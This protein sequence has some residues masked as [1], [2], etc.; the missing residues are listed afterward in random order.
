MLLALNCD[1]IGLG[2]NREVTME[3]D[4]FPSEHKRIRSE[5]TRK[6]YRGFLAHFG[7]FLSD[8][9]L[10]IDAVHPADI[11]RFAAWV[12]GSFNPRTGT[13]GLSDAAVQSHLVAVSSYYKWRRCRNKILPHPVLNPHSPSVAFQPRIMSRDGRG[14]SYCGDPLAR[15]NNS[16]YRRL[17]CV[18]TDS[19]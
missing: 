10:T 2:F 17:S 5:C 6:S 14:V 19:I 11:R 8:N 3:I 13:A 1:L 18:S 7:L 9:K 16:R 15:F 12:K 4:R